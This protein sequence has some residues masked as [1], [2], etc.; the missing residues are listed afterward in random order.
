M[1][2]FSWHWY[3]AI[4]CN[5]K[6]MIPSA[7]G[8]EDVKEVLLAEDTTAD[9]SIGH[10]NLEQLGGDQ[11][12]PPMDLDRSNDAQ[13][14]SA[15]PSASE[16]VSSPAKRPNLRSSDSSDDTSPSPNRSET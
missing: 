9:V 4:I 1:K 3:L 10:L 11:T 12:P 8:S 6:K 15:S 5:L 16:S 7:V 13:S 2:V 14:R